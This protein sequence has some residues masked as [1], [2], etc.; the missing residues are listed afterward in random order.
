MIIIGLTGS[1]ASG[2][3]TVAQLICERNIPVHNSDSAVHNLLGKNGKAV[4][5]VAAVF[6]SSVVMSDGS[7]D[8]KKLGNR[9]FSVP[10]ERAKLELIL[11]PM[12]RQ[13]RELFIE[14][15]KLSGSQKI[16]LEVPL[17]FETKTDQLCNFVIVVYASKDTI[18]KRALARE[19]MT[20]KKLQGILDIQMPALEKCKRADLVL[21]TGLDLTLTRSQ[22]FSWLDGLKEAVKLKKESNNA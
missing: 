17:L 8:R 4:A 18:R 13:I 15:H 20:E 6:G 2:K 9:V 16:V 3:S 7:I 22:L 21:N 10:E 5:D 1:I 14:K 19:G 11:H 12:V